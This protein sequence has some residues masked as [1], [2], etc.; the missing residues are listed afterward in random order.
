[1][2]INWDDQPK[3][4]PVWIEDLDGGRGGWHRDDGD[5]YTSEDGCFWT[6]PEDGYYTAHFKPEIQ[7]AGEGLPPVGLNVEFIHNGSSQG[8]GK[9]LFYGAQRCIIQNTTKGSEGEQ[10]GA[11]EDYI[12]LPIRTQEQIAAEEREEAIKQFMQIGDIYWDTASALYDAGARLPGRGAK[13]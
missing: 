11:I 1:M 5:R 3:G 7:W 9:V 2:D 6:K 13:A 12:F 10:T 4:Y 8:T